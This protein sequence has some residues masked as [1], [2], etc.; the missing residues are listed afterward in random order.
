VKLKINP[1]MQANDAGNSG[2]GGTP[3]P[4]GQPPGA[5]GAGGGAANPPAVDPAVEKR[6]HDS[7]MAAVRRSQEE[8]TPKPDTKKGK[9]GKNAK[10]EE[11]P[12]PADVTKKLLQRQ[13]AFDR[14]IGGKNLNERQLVR[15][16]KAF[17]LEEPADVS[18]WCKEYL[19]DVG[20]STAGSSST[21]GNEN[22]TQ[23]NQ[24]GTKQQ[25]PK[26]PAPGGA[27]PGDSDPYALTEQDVTAMVR[28]HGM[29]GAGTKLMEAL[30]KA[31]PKR[32]QVRRR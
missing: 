9:E 3:A 32:L 24:D 30:R 16:E 20:L 18:T 10:S 23:N 25:P 28:Q 15:M 21:Q 6:I 27:R 11:T 7:V 1:L 8:E 19:E 29:H 5:A 17:E 22:N 13:R 26:V 4:G 14:A 31:P 2:G 12:D